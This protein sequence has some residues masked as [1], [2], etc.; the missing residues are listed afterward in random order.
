MLLVNIECKEKEHYHT[1]RYGVSRE[2]YKIITF[3]KKEDLDDLCC[4]ASHIEGDIS[5]SPEGQVLFIYV[6]K[7][8]LDLFVGPSG[9]WY[10]FQKER[11]LKFI[12]SHGMSEDIPE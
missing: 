8:S 10:K 11:F 5:L 3:F 4:W 2:L 1:E 6:P 9:K 12:R 7:N